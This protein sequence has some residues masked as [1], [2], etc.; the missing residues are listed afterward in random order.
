M[1]CD[2]VRHAVHVVR[3]ADRDSVSDLDRA[4]KVHGVALLVDVHLS[5]L[6]VVG[7]PRVLLRTA[8]LTL[9]LETDCICVAVF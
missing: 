6:L 9:L 4:F 1:E 2:G 8:F 3:A 5:D 7:Q